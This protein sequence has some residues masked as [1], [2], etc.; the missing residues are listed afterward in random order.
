MTHLWPLRFE[1]IFVVGILF[2][3]KYFSVPNKEDIL[4]LPIHIDI[5]KSHA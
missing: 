4:P 3:M 2:S 5:P 1:K